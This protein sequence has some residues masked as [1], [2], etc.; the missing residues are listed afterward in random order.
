MNKIQQVYCK[1]LKT[2]GSQGW[3]PIQGRY[4]KGDYSFPRN[5]AERFEIC[6]GAILTQNTSWKQAEKALLKLKGKSA[7]AIVAVPQ[8][9]LAEL[10]KP[11]G[12]FNQKARKL[13]EFAKFYLKLKGRTPSREELLGIWGIGP[14]TADSILLY[15]YKVPTFVVDAYTKRILESLGLANE[16]ASYDE[17]KRLFE[18]NIK[19]DLKAYQEFH[20]L[21][22]EHAKRYCG[23]K[24]MK[25]RR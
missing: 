23:K 3:W 1:L 15:A 6:I 20:A 22:V 19:S 8:K 9:K 5:S 2:Y 7:K 10:I 17:I 16:K 11:A 24:K 4:H 14:E 25:R 12:Y 21:L 13:K 18:K